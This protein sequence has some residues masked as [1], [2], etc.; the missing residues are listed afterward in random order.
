[1]RRCYDCERIV[2]NIDEVEIELISEFH[3][4]MRIVC[5]RC[6]SFMESLYVFEK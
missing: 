2:E 6:R 4:S 5:S 3:S 1:M